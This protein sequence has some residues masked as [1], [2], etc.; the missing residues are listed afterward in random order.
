M[1]E[2]HKGGQGHDPANDEAHS[3]GIAGGMA[4]FF[5][6]SPLSPVLFLAMLALGILGLIVTPRQEDPQI[7]VPM[8]DIF[9]GYPGASSQQVARLA[10]DPLQRMM[11]EIPKVEHVYAAAQRDHGMV[12][13]QFE[14]G[15]KLGP[16]L[17]KV[18]DKIQ[19]NL[20]KIPPGVR[21]PL[22]RPKG[23]DDVPAVTLTLW[24]PDVDDGA[25]RMLALDVL[26]RLK[27]I[28]DTGT[29][30]IVGGRTEQIRVEVMPERLS[31]FGLSL[32]QVAQTIETANSE[33]QAG[34][35]EA[36]SLDFTVYS[37]AFLRSAEDV[38]RLVVGTRNNTPV[39]VRDIANVIEGPE[40]PRQLVS[41][42]TGPA[43]PGDA[44]TVSNGQ[45]AVTIAIAKKEGSN[46]VTVA[47]AVVRKVEALK[48]RLIP[49]NVK[50][51]ITRDY[52]KTANAKVNE[53]IFKL[54]IATGVVTLLVIFALG[55]R[56]AVV[57]TLVIP[58]VILVTVFA[59]FLMGYTI[60]RVSLF[61]LIFA[62]GILVDD[63][64]VVV[65]NIYRR[66]LMRGETD[67][68]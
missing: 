31:G 19:S 40:E 25:L 26:Q 29:G 13:V 66:W 34:M 46:G 64:I 15:E 3:L 27:E 51:E 41:Y 62:I 14:V 61:A 38:S 65:E 23:I 60:D 59:A 17:V 18:H 48:G 11:S 9:V 47:E 49:P 53:L 32:D 6:Q 2:Q 52:G 33:V 8:V 63:A 56:P 16:S 43:Y 5:I 68:P 37:G 1:S 57:V 28:P 54:F 24:S 67:V 39:Y 10:I 58:V 12:T 20:D 36:N 7:S 4:R 45:P 30:F 44:H 35:V 21:P 50:V 42:Y 55:V 22:V